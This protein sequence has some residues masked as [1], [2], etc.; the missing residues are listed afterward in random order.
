MPAKKSVKKAGVKKTLK[1]A[2]KKTAKPSAKLT[3]VKKETGAKLKQDAAYECGICGFRVIVDE[4]CGCAEE[5]VLI[6]CNK[7]MK[8]KKATKA[9]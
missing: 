7:K 2:A 9:A 1:T 4:L 3:A 5:H 8:E 6:C